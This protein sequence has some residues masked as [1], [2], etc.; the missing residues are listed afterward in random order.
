MFEARLTSASVNFKS[1]Q[2]VLKSLKELLS[3]A[4]FNCTSKGVELQE[5]DNSSQAMVSVS[6]KASAFEHFRCDYSR[7]RMT[8]N[9]ATVDK[10]LEC[11]SSDDIITIVFDPDQHAPEYVRI[12][13]EAPYNEQVSKIQLNQGC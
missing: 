2:D 5:R 10:L 4:T 3:K 11:V 8:L 13:Y 12:N 9:L 6:L 1:V 7:L